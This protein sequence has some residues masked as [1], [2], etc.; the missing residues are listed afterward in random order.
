VIF[1]TQI[2]VVWHPNI[3]FI[4]FEPYQSHLLS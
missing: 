4:V 3:H 2:V 1:T